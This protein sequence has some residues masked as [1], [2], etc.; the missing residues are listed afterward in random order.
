MTLDEREAI[1]DRRL[2]IQSLAVG[3]V[4]T[5]AFALPQHAGAAR[6]RMCVSG[7]HVGRRGMGV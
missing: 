2:L 6:K 7:Q 4:A 3:V 1:V 5:A